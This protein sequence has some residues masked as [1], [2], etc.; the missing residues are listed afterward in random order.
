MFKELIVSR[1]DTARFLASGLLLL[2]LV[3]SIGSFGHGQTSLS[4]PVQHDS[5][6][7]TV[8]PDRSVGVEWNM[9]SSLGTLTQ[10]VSSL[11][12]PGYAI[13]SSSSFSQ[14][15]SAVVQ[16][17]TVQYQLPPQAINFFNSISLTATQTGL[18]SQGSLTISTNVPQSSITG[19]FSTSLTQVRA[20]I[21]ALLYFSPTFFAGTFLANQTIFQK[22]WTKTFAN[23]TWTDHIVGQIQNATSRVVKVTAFNGTLN[24]INTNSVSVSLGF[25]AVPSQ[26]STDFVTA[27]E[28][29]LSTTGTPLPAG[30][31]S[32]IRSA[33]N[34]E[35][36][37]TLT[38]TYTGGST[39]TIVIQSTT[40]YVADLDAQVNKLKT[41]YFQLI[42]SGVPA[43]TVV[44][45]SLLFFNSTSVTISQMSTTS[46]LDLAAGTSSMS[47]KGLLFRPPTV[48]SNTNFTIPGLFQTLGKTPTPGVNFTLVGGSDGTYQ[49]NI[50][51]P[52]SSPQPSS[53]TLNSK[54]WSNLQDASTLSAV[55][56]QLQRLPGGLLAFLVSPVG[57][58]IEAIVAIAIVA[59]VVLYMAKRRASKT[60]LP[61]TAGPTQSPGLGPGPAPPTP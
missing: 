51:V 52:P 53:K 43:G 14:K 4:L 38:L 41:Q 39:P 3:S 36:G 55:Q 12:T 30:V 42:L 25:V 9:T 57:I 22:I 50:V 6:S 58:A 10:N 27:F 23:N 40:N 7:L 15:S 28:S 46:D 37:E 8:N 60:L 34:L 54:T 16:T 19:T 5:L 26:P 45:A 49:I 31:D 33:L 61:T 44:P 21:T 11:F 32:I 24:S 20:N 48:G 59:V 18:T 56:F 13:H 35:T 17:S 1:H 2:A 47:L 29:L